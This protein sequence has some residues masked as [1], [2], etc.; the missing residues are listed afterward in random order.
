MCPTKAKWVSLVLGVL[1][2]SGTRIKELSP[3]CVQSTVLTD[4]ALTHNANYPVG[5][6]VYL[7]PLTQFPL[8][9]GRQHAAL[10]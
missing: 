3:P 9:S 4:N 1:L 10:Y 6:R 8:V 2:I 5:Y 7:T